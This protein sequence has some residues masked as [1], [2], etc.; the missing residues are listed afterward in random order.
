ML[1]LSHPANLLLKPVHI[2]S[3]QDLRGGKHT[4][5]CVC[6]DKTNIWGSCTESE[7]RYLSFEDDVEGVRLGSLPNYHVFVL[8]LHLEKKEET[9]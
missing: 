4:C 9:C 3:H 2:L 5:V 8:I 7:F 6:W 1:P